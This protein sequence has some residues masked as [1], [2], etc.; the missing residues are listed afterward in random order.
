MRTLPYVSAIFV[1][2]IWLCGWQP[3]ESHGQKPTE[4]ELRA[5]LKGL[6]KDRR[7]SA[8]IVL[9][10]RTARWTAGGVG[11]ITMRDVIFAINEYFEAELD[12]A[13]THEQRLALHQ[14]MV[15]QAELIYQ[16]ANGRH[17]SGTLSAGV[18]AEA[19]GRLSK[20]RIAMLRE[21]M[22]GPLD[23]NPRELLKQYSF[24]LVDPGTEQAPPPTPTRIPKPHVRPEKKP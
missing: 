3:A 14:L 1:I 19:K 5:K 4:E 13:E 11:R 22:K 21:R 18:V 10:E 6:M 15:D 12:L 24:A 9:R 16:R 7:D 20:A 17:R 8:V 23:L 2:Q